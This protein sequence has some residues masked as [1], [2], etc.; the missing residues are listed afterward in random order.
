MNQMT[1]TLKDFNSSLK[2]DWLTYKTALVDKKPVQFALLETAKCSKLLNE[3]SVA[4]TIAKPAVKSGVQSKINP[5][6]KARN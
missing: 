5:D 6:V 2:K 1:G 3:K 4:V